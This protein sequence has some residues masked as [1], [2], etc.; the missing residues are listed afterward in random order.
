VIVVDA[1]DPDTAYAFVFENDRNATFHSEAVRHHEETRPFLHPGGE[2]CARPAAER[3]RAGLQRRHFHRIDAVAVR[4]L[5]VEE[6]AS[7]IDDGDRRLAFDPCPVL[8]AGG[9]HLE[10]VLGG[11]GWL[12][13]HWF[14]LLV[15][16]SIER[17]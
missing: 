16:M 2:G 3:S 14:R 12:A 1:G 7:G 17:N 4:P 6:M 10:S 8:L 11:Q 15:G 13:T 5:E 9:H